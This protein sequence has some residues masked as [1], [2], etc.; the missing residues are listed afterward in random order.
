MKSVF[1][2]RLSQLAVASCVAAAFCASASAQTPFAYYN[3]NDPVGADT[4][5]DSEGSFDA[6]YAG[7]GTASYGEGILGG[8][9]RGTGSEDDYFR[10]ADL[11]ALSGVE[12][13]SIS[14]WVNPSTTALFDG[15]VTTR[16]A[17][18]NL[19]DVDNPASGNFGLNQQAN[20]LI[21]ARVQNGPTS[22]NGTDT[23]AGSLPVGQWTHLGYTYDGFDGETKV[24]LNGTLAVTATGLPLDTDWV[25]G[26][27][28]SIGNDADVDNREFNGRIDDLAIF[29]TLVTAGQFSTIATNGNNGIA[30]DGTM[31]ALPGDVDGSGGVTIDDYDIIRSNLFNNV[32]DGVTQTRG[33]GDL[34]ND[35]LVGLADF[36][37]WKENF[38]GSATTV[39]EP[40]SLFLVA[41]FGLITLVAF[42]RGATRSVV[43]CTAVLAVSLAG[44]PASAQTVVATVDQ[45]SGLVTVANTEAGTND[46]SFDG[47]QFTSGNSLLDSAAWANFTD[48]QLVAGWQI[49]STPDDTR[50][51]EALTAAGGISTFP[52]AGSPINFGN[53]FDPSAVIDAQ[54]AAGLGVN[55][56]DVGFGFL[57]PGNS[58]LTNG[59]ISYV[60]ETVTNNLVVKVDSSGN[61]VVENESPFNVTIDGFL[62][63]SAASL[64][65]SWDGSS[66]LNGMGWDIGNASASALGQVNSVGSITLDA[67]VNGVV[68]A[69]GA[70][71]LGNVFVPGSDEDLQ[72]NFVRVGENDGNGFLG[73]V[74]YAPVES[75]VGDYND[76]GV[77]DAADY[78]VFRDNLNTATTIPNDTTPG[79]VAEEDYTV[80]SGNYGAG[81]APSFGTAVPEPTTFGLALLG[82]VAMLRRRTR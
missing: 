53:L 62:L 12:D 47:Y 49:L 16:S 43:G 81:T 40:N 4:L 71:E 25:T 22:S 31:N 45:A 66:T 10:T 28:W 21:D 6:T 42:R 39:P 26:G 33:L 69:G 38:G 7:A 20:D 24:Y 80:W 1:N 11:T 27:V 52:G 8:A 54:L 56:L 18:T 82:G 79:T 48:V 59:T 51:A 44:A 32:S 17:E 37:Q 77:V 74:E 75:L 73:A 3:F 64:D 55:V 67:A 14:V 23:A 72:F 15:L 76:D 57:E 5:A 34:T 13:L 58:T 78:T 36:R 60:G 70:V 29:D 2:Y 30:F 61:A 46:A 41:T 35:G 65:A 50:V 9:W 63:S 19:G 68:Q